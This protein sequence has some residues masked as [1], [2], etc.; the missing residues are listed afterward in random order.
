MPQSQEGLIWCLHLS[1][2]SLIPAWANPDVP[3]LSWCSDAGP[4]QVQ[5]GW[6]GRLPSTPG[7]FYPWAQATCFAVVLGGTTAKAT[8]YS[9]AVCA[10]VC[11]CIRFEAQL[12]KVKN[13]ASSKSECFLICVSCLC[14]LVCHRS[15]LSRDALAAFQNSWGFCSISV[16]RPLLDMKKSPRLH[17]VD[18]A[19]ENSDPH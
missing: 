1:L 8:F 10:Q 17:K 11:S 16:S 5:R 6:W 19:V 4:G 18:R 3:G 7:F 14:S 9:V 12:C 15:D 13:V 2:G